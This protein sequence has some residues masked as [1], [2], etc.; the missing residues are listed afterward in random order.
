MTG[1]QDTRP[2]PARM[3][4]VARRA[5]VS[6]ATV[7]RSIRNPEK[8]SE[9]TRRRVHKAVRDLGYV[10]NLVAGS[11]AANRTGIIAALVPTFDNRDYAKTIHATAEVLRAAGYHLLLG[12]HGFSA[13]QEEAL[14]A[15]FLGRRPDGFFLHGRQHTPG[16]V[17]MLRSSGIPVVESG[18]LAGRP[19][20][21]VVSY[22]N[23]DAAKA[24][25]HHLLE[26]GYRRI[27]L[28]CAPWR[29]SERHYR[30]WRGYRAALREQG[31]AYSARRFIE[32]T[33]L[34]M[35][36]GAEALNTLLDRDPHIDAI[37]FTSDVLA[38]GALLACQRRGWPIPDRVAIT[39]F[40]DQDIASRT[41]PPLTTVRLPREEIG[42][43]AGQMILDRLAGRGIKS[44]VVNV[45]FQLMDRESA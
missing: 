41:I 34:S 11:L 28:V 12:H 42:R 45:G 4:D 22:S 33:V 1:A 24:L 8:V 35:D 36:Q 14:I 2:G 21:M 18:D 38:I 37:F 27:A 19:V 44:N 17:Q 43:V 9:R 3:E 39:G 7:S 16:A 40:D 26:K 10:H 29:E 20:D 25:T 32:T 15:A 5:R 6:T 23:F 30:R 13:N 31:V